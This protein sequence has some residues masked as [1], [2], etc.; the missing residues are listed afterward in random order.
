VFIRIDVEAPPGPCT[1]T[2][3]HPA[4]VG[5]AGISILTSD[6]HSGVAL[7][8]LAG[9]GRRSGARRFDRPPLLRKL[10]IIASERTGIGAANRPLDVGCVFGPESVRHRSGRLFA[11]IGYHLLTATVVE[12]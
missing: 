5:G 8:A 3:D 2:S 6:N 11:A 9:L 4:V 7:R 10:K 12:R 1:T